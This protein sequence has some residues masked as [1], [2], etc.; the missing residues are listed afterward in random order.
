MT[1]DEQIHNNLSS[2]NLDWD[3]LKI[4][5]N[6]S[7]FYIESASNK[8]KGK[9]DEFP[10]YN[11]IPYGMTDIP[12]EGFDYEVASDQPGIYIGGIQ[13]TSPSINQW[14][15]SSY[16]TLYIP[17]SYWDSSSGEYY[18]I[19]GMFNLEDP[20]QW[21]CFD[22]TEDIQTGDYPG[23]Y[24]SGFQDDGCIKNLIFSKKINFYKN[25]LDRHMAFQNCTSF[26]N[27]LVLP[28]SIKVLTPDTFANTNITGNLDLSNVENIEAE[29]FYNCSQLDGTLTLGKDLIELNNDCFY[30]CTGIHTINCYVTDKKQILTNYYPVEVYTPFRN[31]G[32]SGT[33]H[34][35]KD[36]NW[37]SSALDLSTNYDINNYFHG[38]NAGGWKIVKDL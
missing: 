13:Q 29:A 18:P 30:G 14:N 10:I 11:N 37:T 5:N 22:Q 3:K 32:S 1:I 4:Q 16:D 27:E 35:P 26:T 28:S 38:L 7:S 17:A 12:N 15:L 33:I 6:N 36:S 25:E 34:V 8:Y 9:T 21:G 31:C 20:D 23:S 2:L 19:A 24:N